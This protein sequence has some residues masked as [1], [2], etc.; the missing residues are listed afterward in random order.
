M[1]SFFSANFAD[2]KDAN[3]AIN[4]KKIYP[5]TCSSHVHHEQRVMMTTKVS[6]AV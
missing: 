2:P 5:W 6:I 1:R 4:V 3:N